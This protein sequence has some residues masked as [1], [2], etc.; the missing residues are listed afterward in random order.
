MAIGERIRFFRNLRGMTQKYLGTVVGFPEKTADIRMAQYES[1]SRTP[2]ADLT[3]S[4]AG[5]LGVSPLAL[6]VPD[7]DS[8]L[9][10]MHTLFTLEDLY[11]FRIDKLDDELCIR[12]DKGK[13]TNYLKMFDMF[14]AWQ[15]QAKKFKNGEITKEEYDNWRYNYPKFNAFNSNK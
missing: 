10:L 2:K 6:S 15:E 3:E 8:Y 11:G 5:V 9:G 13:G 12:L 14:S 4:L 1:G 7:I